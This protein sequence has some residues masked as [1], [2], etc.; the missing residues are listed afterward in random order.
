MKNIPL[1]VRVMCADGECGRSSHVIINPLKEVIT[2]V[3]VES[4]RLDEYIVELNLN[5]K[6]VKSLPAIP[7]KRMYSLS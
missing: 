1:N 5:K 7:L 6:T 4:D 2:Y 3:V